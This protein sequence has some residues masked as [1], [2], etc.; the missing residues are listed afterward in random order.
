MCAPYEN[1]IIHCITAPLLISHIIQKTSA[2][3]GGL[4]EPS[5]MSK[6]TVKKVQLDKLKGAAVGSKPITDF[7]GRKSPKRSMGRLNR[8]SS[9]YNEEE[10][11]TSE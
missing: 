5:E 2:T 6:K 3:M 4:H 7:F 1:R 10:E 11:E 9:S 8:N